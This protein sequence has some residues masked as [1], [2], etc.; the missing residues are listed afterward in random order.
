MGSGMFLDQ[1]VEFFKHLF[2]VGEIHFDRD[3]VVGDLFDLGLDLLLTRL[4]QFHHFA[5]CDLGELVVFG[6][7]DLDGDRF[8]QIHLRQ[9]MFSNIISS[10]FP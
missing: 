8:F 9:V 3:R 10:M 2:V 1:G 4:I 7:R 6:D 5:G